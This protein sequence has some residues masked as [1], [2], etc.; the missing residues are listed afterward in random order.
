MAKQKV[1]LELVDSRGRSF[2]IKVDMHPEPYSVQIKGRRRWID[3][4]LIPALEDIRPQLRDL[5]ATQFAEAFVVQQRRLKAARQKN[6]A[7]TAAIFR[8]AAPYLQHKPPWTFQRIG[9]RIAGKT[10]K[11]P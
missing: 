8:E 2:P 7:M 11:L 6:V 3:A 4:A 1:K 10:V 5:A 9:K